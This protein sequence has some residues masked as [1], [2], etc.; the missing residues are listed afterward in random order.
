MEYQLELKKTNKHRNFDTK[1]GQFII[2]KWKSQ[3]LS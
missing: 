2:R 3:R 1:K